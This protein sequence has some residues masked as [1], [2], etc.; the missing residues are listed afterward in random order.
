[1]NYFRIFP[2]PISPSITSSTT[3]LERTVGIIKVEKC[4]MQV[5]YLEL[6]LLIFCHCDWHTLFFSVF[7][8]KYLVQ[9]HTVCLETQRLQSSNSQPWDH[10][11]LEFCGDGSKCSAKSKL[12]AF[13]ALAKLFSH[14]VQYP[15]YD[16]WNYNARDIAAKFILYIPNRVTVLNLCLFLCSLFK[17]K[18][19]I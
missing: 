3:V 12:L 2:F 4:L 8:N 1:M 14:L 19:H 17:A 6:F 15:R 11:T 18:N 13:L 16:L 10:D 9:V 7:S 5:F